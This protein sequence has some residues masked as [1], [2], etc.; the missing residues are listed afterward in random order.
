MFRIYYYD[1][2]LLQKLDYSKS[3]LYQV[4]WVNSK[5][6]YSARGASPEV[7]KRREQIQSEKKPETRQFFRPPGFSEFAISSNFK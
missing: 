5:E 2:T 6:K 3:E 7:L 1:G 4:N